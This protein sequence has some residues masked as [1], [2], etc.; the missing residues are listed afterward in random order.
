MQRVVGSWL[1]FY[2]SI[3][4]VFFLFGF[5]W[6]IFDKT[7]TLQEKLNSINAVEQKEVGDG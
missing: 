3:I 1:V 4:N 5:I 6:F 7:L 2:F